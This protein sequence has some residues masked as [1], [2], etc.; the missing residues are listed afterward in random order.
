M[1]FH[2]TYS[3]STQNR[4]AA[5]SR[6]KATGGLPPEGATMLGR[7]HCAQGLKGF[8]VAEASDAEAIAMWIQQWSDLLSFEITPVVDDDQIS[9]VIG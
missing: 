9:R 4:D 8:I 1:L 3:L 5:Q 7:W 2:I 6:F